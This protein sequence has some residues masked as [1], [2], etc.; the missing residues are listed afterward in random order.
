MDWK[1]L[2]ISKQTYNR[3]GSWSCI[4]PF[5]LSCRAHEYSYL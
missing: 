4:R 3:D 1:R 2:T 5:L